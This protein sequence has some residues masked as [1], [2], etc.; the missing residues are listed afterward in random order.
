MH[1]LVKSV[2]FL[3]VTAQLA[4]VETQERTS[5]SELIARIQDFRRTALRDSSAL[6]LCGFAEAFDQTGRVLPGFTGIRYVTQSECAAKRV[7]GVKPITVVLERII[8]TPELILISGYYERGD[9]RYSEEY[10]FIVRP[11]EIELHYAITS[12][13]IW[14]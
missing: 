6:D 11:T 5:L 8:R 14:R 10:R 7:Q 2:M 9:L 1:R 12:S 4:S 3:C 13:V